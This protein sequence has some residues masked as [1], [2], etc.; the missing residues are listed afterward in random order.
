MA[1]VISG[2]ARGASEGRHKSRGKSEARHNGAEAD[3]K[4]AKFPKFMATR[5]LRH[6]STMKEQVPWYLTPLRVGVED[7][8]MLSDLAYDT[9]GIEYHVHLVLDTVDGKETSLST[10]LGGRRIMWLIQAAAAAAQS[11][12]NGKGAMFQKIA[13]MLG[14]VDRV[15]TWRAL[16][17][18]ALIE[19]ARLSGEVL[20]WLSRRIE[21]RE[22]GKDDRL[23]CLAEIGEEL[24]VGLHNYIR[25]LAAT[26]KET[27]LTCVVQKYV[28]SILVHFA[29]ELVQDILPS[30]GVNR[31]RPAAAIAQKVKAVICNQESTRSKLLRNEAARYQTGATQYYKETSSWGKRRGGLR[32]HLTQ[33]L[34]R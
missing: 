1:V 19:V 16:P 10:A 4:V 22:T 5:L 31:E 2:K 6:C 3:D 9:A 13:S 15:V 11:A 33:M 25:E 17:G 29:G 27:L 14:M 18:G 8:G 7:L 34:Q 24:A 20:R 12:V 30:K 21:V 28:S 26:V 32:Q 23:A